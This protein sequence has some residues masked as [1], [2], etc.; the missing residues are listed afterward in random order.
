MRKQ[1]LQLAGIG[2]LSFALTTAAVAGDNFKMETPKY[3]GAL[4]IVTVYAMISALSWD[5]YAG[6]AIKGKIVLILDH[7]PGER[8]PTSPF[9]GVVTAEAA[10]P[11]PNPP[12]P[13]FLPAEASAAH[14]PQPAP[15]PAEAGVPPMQPVGGGG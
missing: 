9:D 8:D 5:N 11:F 12:P 6:D 2:A 13:G 10:V 14:G 3:G 7:E 15:L 4:E 1:A